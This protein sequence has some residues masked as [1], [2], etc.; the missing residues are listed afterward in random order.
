MTDSCSGFP[1]IFQHE[2]QL[3]FFAFDMLVTQAACSHNVIE[4]NFAVYLLDLPSVA[5]ELGSSV[6]YDNLIGCMQ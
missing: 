6:A 1:Q 4:S 5:Y 2:P 3:V